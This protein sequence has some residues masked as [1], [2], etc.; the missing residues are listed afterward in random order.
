MGVKYLII[1]AKPNIFQNIEYPNKSSLP[2][3]TSLPGNMGLI[4]VILLRVILYL[5]GLLG[6]FNESI[7]AEHLEIAEGKLLND[8]SSSSISESFTTCSMLRMQ[9]CTSGSCCSYSK[10]TFNL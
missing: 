4:G 5:T 3:L 1:L 9:C 2:G 10:Q 8:F 7:D 6:H